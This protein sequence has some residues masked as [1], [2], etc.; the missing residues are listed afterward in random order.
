MGNFH[1]GEQQKA[2][3]EAEKLLAITPDYWKDGIMREYALW[4]TDTLGMWKTKEPEMFAEGIHKVNELMIDPHMSEQTRRSVATGYFRASLD[5]DS[6][7]IGP[8]FDYLH[9]FPQDVATTVEQEWRSDSDAVWY[10]FVTKASD[11]YRYPL[12]TNQEQL[13]IAAMKSDLD[14]AQRALPQ[15]KDLS[16]RDKA[17]EQLIYAFTDIDYRDLDTARALVGLIQDDYI[18]SQAEE[19]I[20]LEVER[21]NRGETSAWKK[22]EQVRRVSKAN[23]NYLADLL[24]FGTEV[25]GKI[26]FDEFYKRTGHMNVTS[27]R[28]EP[29]QNSIDAFGKEVARIKDQVGVTVNLD[30]DAVANIL[31]EGRIK[32]MWENEEVVNERKKTM[33]YDYTARRDEV[34]RGLGNKAKG[35]A[36]DPHPIYGAV[37]SPNGRDEYFGAALGYGMCF[38][39]LKTENIAER[40]SVIYDDSFNVFSDFPV[41]WSD[42]TE[43]KAMANVLDH[44]TAHKYVEAQVLNGVQASD[45]D[46]INIPK[47]VLEQTLY[48]NGQEA[49][50]RIQQ[51]IVELRK[52]YP[53]VQINIL[54][55]ADAKKI[56]EL[57]PKYFSR[58]YP[59][60]E[61]YW[62]KVASG[63]SKID[64]DSILNNL[65]LAA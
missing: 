52:K 39:K 63:G 3:T 61:E 1:K 57:L 28:S 43:V 4:A 11:I 8:L 46:S 62:D 53:D 10:Q 36:R 9:R 55:Q 45:I 40:T 18:R 26:A 48:E 20:Q 16:L 14:Y 42:A 13:N 17:T 29:G 47:A 30:W 50:S 38:V 27:A 41:L 23:K 60:T 32:S 54:E 25:S 56:K 34:E 2:L 22:M 49:V 12:G 64:F 6:R 15:I 5:P 7:N 19:T 59:G 24:G 44:Q 58:I 65:A 31:D 33:N 37:Y 35:G 51:Q 21:E